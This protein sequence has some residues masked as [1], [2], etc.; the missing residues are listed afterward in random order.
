[1]DEKTVSEIEFVGE[2]E[3]QKGETWLKN[4]RET[5][6]LKQL[7]QIRRPTLYKFPKIRIN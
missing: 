4:R 7:D 3:G 2:K 6:K 1:M 5:W